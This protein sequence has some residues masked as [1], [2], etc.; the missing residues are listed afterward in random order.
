[1]SE[2]RLIYPSHSDKKEW[3]DWVISNNG[4]V[5]SRTAYLDATADNWCIVKNNLGAIACPFTIKLGVRILYTPFFYRY[6]EWIGKDC[7]F[8]N[9]L[10]FLKSNFQVSHSQIKGVFDVAM[11]T[12]V[13]QLIRHEISLNQHAKRMLKK[14]ERNTFKLKWNTTYTLDFLVD[15]I[16]N[17]LA[18]KLEDWDIQMISRLKK[19]V[20][21]LN[22][23]NVLNVLILEKDDE[24]GGVLF[25]VSGKHELVYLKGTCTEEIKQ[26]GGMYALMYHLIHFGISTEKIIDFGGSTVEGVRRFNTSF[27]GKDEIYTILEWNDAPFFWKILKS[28]KDRWIKK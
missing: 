18:R 23:S 27:G 1:M 22:E 4:S 26:E 20:Q 2:Y 8:Q 5:F 28:L 11:K 25:I 6:M 10:R 13:H 19:L 7:D 3:D 16:G 9:L 12:R 17:E 24:L 21:S 15:F 14:S